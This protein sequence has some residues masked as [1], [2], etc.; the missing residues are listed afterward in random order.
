MIESI[1]FPGG[2]PTRLR[3]R[4]NE[5]VFASRLNIVVGYNGS[6][7]STLLRA[8]AASAGLADPIEADTPLIVRDEEPILY[9]TAADPNPLFDHKF[10]EKHNSLRSDGEVRIGLL[11]ELRTHLRDRFPSYAAD[12]SRRPVLLLDEPEHHLSPP[13]QFYLWQTVLPML[14]KQFQLIVATH[15]VFP[16]LLKKESQYTRGDQMIILSPGYEEETVNA[17]SRAVDQYNREKQP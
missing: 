1:R 16:V 14:S 9:Q 10:L 2:Y 12:A 7:K 6:G 13:A 17:L 4:K 8:L 15:S 3:F 11:N 5:I